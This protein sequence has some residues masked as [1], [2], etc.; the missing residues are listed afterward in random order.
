[1]ASANIV[2]QSG[3]AG[4]IAARIGERGAVIIGLGLQTLACTLIGLAPTGLFFSAAHLPMVFGNIAGPSIQALM[5]AKVAPDEQGRLQG[6]LGSLSGLTGFVAPIAFTQVFAW[7]IGPGRGGAW[8][9]TTNLAAAG[10]SL[11]AWL[12]VMLWVKPSGATEPGA[13]ASA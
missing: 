10:L 8:S 11:V 9:G 13:I 7:S 3:L 4:R 12:L 6:A 2:V 5:T 1:L